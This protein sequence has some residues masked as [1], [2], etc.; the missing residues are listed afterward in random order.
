MISRAQFSCALNTNS[1]N[2][3]ELGK[4]L[5]RTIKLLV[6]IFTHCKVLGL[7]FNILI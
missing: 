7:N 3:R 5:I 1:M 4:Q 6:A 2:T